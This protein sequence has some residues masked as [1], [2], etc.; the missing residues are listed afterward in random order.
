MNEGWKRTRWESRGQLYCSTQ[1]ARQQISRLILQSKSCALVRAGNL[2]HVFHD[3]ISLVIAE[4]TILL[5]AK[6]TQMLAFCGPEGR[7][8]FNEIVFSL[9]PASPCYVCTRV[10]ILGVLKIVCCCE[11]KSWSPYACCGLPFWLTPLPVLLPHHSITVLKQQIL[12]T[13]APSLLSS[14]LVV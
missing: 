2:L 7:S 11:N 6:E 9:R 1:R 3:L 5:W 14:H 12:T 13:K 4:K 8:D 10:V